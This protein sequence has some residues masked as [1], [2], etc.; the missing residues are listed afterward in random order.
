MTTLSTYLTFGGN[1]KEAMEFYHSCLGGKINIQLVKDSPMAEQLKGMEDK[2][3]HSV[4]ERDGLMLMASD[5]MGEGKAES[6]NMISLCI[7]GDEKEVREMFEKMSKGGKVGQSLQ[8]VFFG[9]YGDMV[10]KFGIRWMFQADT[11]EHHA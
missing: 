1:C 4:L 8:E 3:M 2:V 5:M 9:L 6:G 11:K 7:S 10:D